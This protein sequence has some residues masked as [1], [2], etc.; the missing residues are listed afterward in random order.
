VVAGLHLNIFNSHADRVRGANIAQTVN[1]L[2][3]MVLTRGSEMVLTPTYHVFDLYQVHQDAVLLPMSVQSDWYALDGDSVPAVSASASRDAEGRI[4]LTLAN[5]DP[6]RART[7]RV[8][9]RGAQ[10]AAVTGR[11]LT[12]A[13]MN[14]HNTFAQPAA[15][16]PA[17]F[18]GARLAGTLLT[19]ELPSKSVV[20]LELR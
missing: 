6:N 12:A 14:A 1:V 3:A 7:L 15:V 5:L 17:P 4:H 13:A 11:V 20:A 10:P 19:V 16:Q 9:I 2:Q 18:R 8:E